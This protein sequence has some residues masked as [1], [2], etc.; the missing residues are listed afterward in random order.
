MKKALLSIWLLAAAFMAQAQTKLLFEETLTEAYLLKY[1]TTSGGASQASINSIISALATSS[2]RTKPEFVVRY[3]QQSRI[4]DN[5]DQLQLKVQL[6]RIKVGGDVNYKGFDIS[7]VLLPEKLNF[8]VKLL[9]AQ[10]KEIKSY[11]YTNI[12]F[13][14]TGVV[15]ADFTIPDTAANQNYKLKVEDKELVYTSE[16]V[17]R[18][19]ERLN[20]VRDYYAAETT[21]NVA[22][23]DIQRITPDDIDRISHHD[24]NLSQMEELFGRLQAADYKEK[25][26]L[27]QYDPQNLASKM[28]QLHQLLKERRRAIDYALATLDQQFYNRG[29]GM[30]TGGN[31]RAAQDYFIKSLEVNP[32]FAP[33]HLQLARLDF[34][35]GY[36]KEAA[37]R[38]RDML[39]GMRI[40]PETE[41]MTLVLANDIYTSYLSQGNNL[42]SRGDYNNA[43]AAFNDARE[44]CS[45]GGVRCNMPALND[46]EGRAALG[47]YKSIIAEGKR[48]LSL[49]NL[50]KA[51]QLAAEALHFQKEYD[52]YL[53]TEPQAT[54]LQNQVKY[55]FYVQNID[56]G[57]RYLNEKNYEA[58]LG[59]FEEALELEQNYTFKY[60][61]ELGLLTQKAAKPVLLAKL[62]DGYQQAMSNQL[63]NAREV[64]SVTLAMQTRYA[65]EQDADIRTKYNLLRDRIFTQECINT[66]AAYDKHFQAAKE[67]IKAK[68]FI[69]ADMAYQAAI[70]AADDMATCNIATFTAKD[71]REAIAAAAI[72]QRMLEEAAHFVYSSRYTEA[73]LKYNE[74]EKQYLTNDVRRFGLNHISL[75]NYAKDNQKLPFTAAVVNHFASI[76]EEQIAVQLLNVLL[77]KDYP[78]RKTKKVQEQL[79]K[80]LAAKDAQLGLKE[81][82]EALAS[83]HTNNNRDL[84][85]LRKAYEKERKRISKA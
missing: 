13:N 3:E 8:K 15:L 27:R 57:K 81:D 36:I 60:V 16:S 69:S 14:K 28:S 52:N 83:K 38:T 48:A 70:K 39:K 55:Q 12:A 65:L 74:A 22:L 7:E 67:L 30:L 45:I 51:E 23:R 24:R 78:R 1:N 25:L 79:G 21:I 33:A 66:Q 72:Y 82:V 34:V 73:I 5:G 11:T 54:E 18:V 26:N 85:K 19:Q 35:N 84:K 58:A 40:D 63:A 46:G 56:K 71:G 50:A 29:V 64:A 20:L 80:Q 53:H 42:I 6:D 41:Q 4:S 68:Q 62:N 17:R 43:L 75:F 49:N 76:G 31:V 47:A 77:E 10:N 61:Q 59:Q 32:K 9:N 37:G 2:G 44:M